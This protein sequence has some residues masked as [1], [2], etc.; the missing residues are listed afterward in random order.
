MNLSAMVYQ[1]F[2]QALWTEPSRR[3]LI[4]PSKARSCSCCTAR[5]ARKTSFIWPSPGCEITANEREALRNIGTTEMVKKVV[6][7]VGGTLEGYLADVS[8][9]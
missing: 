9:E 6:T 8:Q 1:W 2:A 7:S 3:E 4:S 5:A